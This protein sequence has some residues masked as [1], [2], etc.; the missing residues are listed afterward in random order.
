M[1]KGYWLR[2]LSQEGLIH[3]KEAAFKKSIKVPIEVSWV[4]TR[5]IIAPPGK[6]EG[7]VKGTVIGS[8]VLKVDRIK[9]IASVSMALSE[10]KTLIGGKNYYIA[11][12]SDGTLLVMFSENTSV[13]EV[14][15]EGEYR[16]VSRPGRD[17]ELGILIQSVIG[18]DNPTKPFKKRVHARAEI[19]AE[20]PMETRVSVRIE[21]ALW[22]VEVIHVDVFGEYD[23]DIGN[24]RVIPR[25]LPVTKDLLLTI[26]QKLI[27]PRSIQR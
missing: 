15:T 1:D 10:R 12:A 14:H 19:L 22:I 8:L 21:D 7:K 18:K 25:S 16:R 2:A 13:E 23:V 11:E 20:R 27:D 17:S 5:V 24:L 4:P 9:L 3:L 26:L 6:E